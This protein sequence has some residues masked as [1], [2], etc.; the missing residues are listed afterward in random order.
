MPEKLTNIVDGSKH[1]YYDLII[2]QKFYKRIVKEANSTIPHL[3][4]VF[5]DNEEARSE[6][7]DM[8]LRQKR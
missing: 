8:L 5:D 1:K 3:V 4:T 6:L 2:W 7:K